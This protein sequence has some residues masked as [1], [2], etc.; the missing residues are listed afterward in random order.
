[1]QQ[2]EYIELCK[3]CDTI[4][5]SCGLNDPA[6][7]SIST[8]HVLNAHPLN[9]A[10][11]EPLDCNRHLL[12]LKFLATSFLRILR[13]IFRSRRVL[14][15]YCVAKPDVIIFSHLLRPE[16]L[17]DTSDFYFGSLSEALSAKGKRSLFVLFNHTGLQAAHLWT[18]PSAKVTSRLPVVNLLSPF[19]E[20]SIACTQ[21]L[22]F[23]RFRRSDISSI[24]NAIPNLAYEPLS[25]RTSSNLRFY[26]QTL[27][28]L[29]R[30]RPTSVIVTYEG[31]AWERLAFF[32]ARIANPRVKCI[33]YQHAII[34]PFQHSIKRSLGSRFD[35]D[36]VLFAGKYSYNWFY[37]FAD[38]K[39][40][41]LVAGT[42][43]Y[44][45]PSNSILSQPCPIGFNGSCLLLPD[46]T[47]SESLI[48]YRFGLD[49]ARH[50]IDTR[51]VF[52]L[53]P[54]L[55]YSDLLAVDSSLCDHPPNFFVSEDT[56]Y[57]DFLESRWAIYQG[58][59]AGVRAAT[60]GLR[61]IYYNISSI[62]IS[63]DP[64]YML[65]SWRREAKTVEDVASVFCADL[66]A[67]PSSIDH[68]YLS[69]RNE[70]EVYFRPFD[71]STFI[72][73]V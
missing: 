65:S 18:D 67:P 47:L 73:H 2:R 48:L 66:S 6:L 43:R 31:H 14:P 49:C 63:I 55:A 20:F 33:A 42:P 68:E 26:K 50:L 8:L 16:Q 40:A 45:H 24:V 54:V 34:F 37:R 32:A 11:Y 61:P 38:F 41:G 22:L 28:L 57:S 7:M 44:D 25:L 9:I 27:S 10:S 71:L 64:L 5:L 62:H 1:M 29:K 52:R 3:D 17:N 60:S 15:A 53:H 70:L 56:I 36:I 19:Q 58:S 23:M 59:G 12:F 35:P 30:F 46:G 69:V 51:F 72:Q 4:L 21:I 39:P 13:A